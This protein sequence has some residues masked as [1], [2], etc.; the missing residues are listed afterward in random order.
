[1]FKGINDIKIIYKIIQPRV[2][3]ESG[4]EFQTSTFLPLSAWFVFS[5][6]QI[7]CMCSSIHSPT[8][9]TCQQLKNPFIYKLA[10]HSHAHLEPSLYVG[11]NLVLYKT[12]WF[13]WTNGMP[14][15][16]KI[17]VIR[18]GSLQPILMP[19]IGQNPGLVPDILGWI[20]KF[21]SR[22]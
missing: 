8:S 19:Q 15:L 17:G 13:Y 3:L 9:S 16:G 2:S 10:Q 12:G 22:I 6:S 5:E 1:M 21:E 7:K 11:S 4:Y 14:V 18:P 20:G